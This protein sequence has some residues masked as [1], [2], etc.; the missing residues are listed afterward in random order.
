MIIACIWFQVKGC[1]PIFINNTY[2]F[3]ELFIKYDSIVAIAA[4][5][6]PNIEIRK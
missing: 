4:P 1:N 5:T 2:D 3:E 6:P